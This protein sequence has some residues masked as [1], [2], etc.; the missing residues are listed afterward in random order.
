MKFRK[1]IIVLAVASAMFQ[2][3]EVS[4]RSSKPRNILFIAVDDLKPILGCYGD[5]LIKTPNIDR[6]ADAGTVFLN[7]HCQQAVCGPSRAS[8]M[9]GLRPDHTQVRDLKTRMRDMNPQVVSLPQYLRSQGY[10][11]AGTGKIYDPRCVDKQLDEPSWSIPYTRPH[12][13]PYDSTFGKP[14]LGSYQ[15]AEIRAVN[16]EAEKKGLKK[17]A[18]VKKFL[19]AHDAW[20][21]VESADVPDGAYTDGAIAADGIQLMKKLKREGKPFFLAV[22]FKKPHLP[23][24]APSKYWNLYKR[25]DFKTASFQGKTT[26]PVEAAYHNSSE[27]RTYGGI[28][29]FDSYSK[30]PAKH[31]STEKQKE[32][33]HGYYACT[34]YIDTL[35]GQL[36][37][38]LKALGLDKDTVIVLWG[39]HGWHLGDHGLWCKHTN[40]EQATRSPL[41]I[42]DPSL[43]GAKKTVSPSEFVDLF[44]T[45]CELAGVPVPGNLDGTSLVPVLKDPKATVKEYAVSQWPRGKTM[46]YAIRDGRY[47]YVEWFTRL[48]STQPYD[49]DKIE[50]RE[51]YDY[52]KDPLETKNLVDDPE[53]KAVVKKMNQRMQD[54]FKAQK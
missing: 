3:L 2:T 25:D 54:F 15:G 38:E 48:N 52:E 33:I 7:N 45:L 49:S 24:V 8:L 50:G 6:L 40:F 23:F 20:P 13:L 39:D 18:D 4:A 16:N 35:V 27:L 28:P 31:M 36:L 19:V 42:V 11:T 9:T 47:R 12:Q 53:Y 10:E 17:Y 44:P 29:N 14:V 43:S 26:N 30:D 46:G 41:I 37:D 22:G 32:L 21:A 1:I 34:S 51:L 5:T